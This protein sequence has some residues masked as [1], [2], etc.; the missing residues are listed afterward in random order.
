MRATLTWPMCAGSLSDTGMHELADAACLALQARSCTLHCPA[1]IFE[2]LR[3][4][5]EFYEYQP[6][7]P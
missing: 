3:Y 5:R 2:G 6:L 7:I 4:R 1:C